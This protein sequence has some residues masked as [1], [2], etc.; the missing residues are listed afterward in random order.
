MT[1][2]TAL[3]QT[4]CPSLLWIMPIS[5]IFIV[6][7]VRS[8][9]EL[10][11]NVPESIGVLDFATINLIQV[12]VEEFEVINRREECGEGFKPLLTSYW[13]GTVPGCYENGE[14][15]SNSDSCDGTELPR[16]DPIELYSWGDYEFCAK[17]LEDYDY[18]AADEECGS[19]QR[20]CS[21][22]LCTNK[23]SKCPI[24]SIQLVETNDGD[25][26]S[27]Y[28]DFETKMLKISRKQDESPFT[29]LDVINGKLCYSYF[30][31][32]KSTS[33]YP[34]LDVD[35]G[36]GD[37][38]STTNYHELSTRSEENYYKDNLLQYVFT[39]LPKYEDYLRD[40]LS[41]ISVNQI[42]FT[43]SS[44]CVNSVKDLEEAFAY[45]PTSKFPFRTMKMVTIIIVEGLIVLY[46]IDMLVIFINT[47]FPTRSHN[48]NLI[49]CIVVMVLS[50]IGTMI[51][52]K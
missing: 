2:K 44:T 45:E 6:F 16:K 29:I 3:K 31:R 19:N 23:D 28:V 49:G 41:L 34:I 15:S 4:N 46:C 14:L 17:Y 27:S 11:V 52:S 39:E 20:K 24:T 7:S 21:E 51:A 40:I 48:I 32:G 22:G 26:D 10:K 33:F 1:A 12:P 37:W 25:E 5:I 18:V 13:P 42:D 35:N 50:C 30:A 36:C 38:G 8:L 9:F 43:K 47:K